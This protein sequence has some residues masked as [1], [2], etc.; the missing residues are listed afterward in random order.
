[1][2]SG[3]SFQPLFSAAFMQQLPSLQQFQSQLACLQ[4]QSASTMTPIRKA[5]V[6]GSS[7]K[8]AKVWKYFDQLPVEEQA[9]ECQLCRK[10]IKA[11]NSSTTGMIRHL[12]SCHVAEYQLLQEARQS[13]IKFDEK[14]AR[15]GLKDSPQTSVLQQK[16]PSSMSSASDT[17]SSLSTTASPP[18]HPLQTLTNTV[19]PI[20]PPAGLPAPKPLKPVTAKIELTEAEEEEATD[21]RTKPCTPSIGTAFSV[22]RKASAFDE[23]PKSDPLYVNPSIDVMKLNSQVAMMLLLDGHPSN[24]VDRP[25]FRGLLSPHN[26]LGGLAA[27]NQPP[28]HATSPLDMSLKEETRPLKEEAVTTPA[29]DEEQIRIDEDSDSASSAESERVDDGKAKDGNALQAT[30]DPSLLTAL[31][32]CRALSL[33][34]HSVSLPT[35]HPPRPSDPHS[36]PN[37]QQDVAFVANNVEQ[38]NLWLREHPESGLL[39]VSEDEKVVLNALHDQLQKCATDTPESR[40]QIAV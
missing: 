5:R 40:T 9:A 18:F 11:T 15:P 10:K 27:M 4:Q 20:L 19:S 13:S 23:P 25:G 26:P 36:G 12:R 16:S 32:R 2:L 37:V 29:A 30:A 24:I 33:V 6:G 31:Q 3:G 34:F 8:T 22:V 38:I 28:H 14:P 17:T 1:M 7:V 21:L 39:E 35:S